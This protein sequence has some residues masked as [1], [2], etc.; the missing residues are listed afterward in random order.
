MPGSAIETQIVDV[1]VTP[2]EIADVL[3]KYREHHDREAFRNEV[4]PLEVTSMERIFR[5]L[6]KRH[7]IDFNH[8][9]PTTIG[10]RVKRR[11]E[12]DGAIG[13]IDDY[14][15]LLEQ[16]SGKL[17][18]L[19]RDLL[20]GVTRFFRDGEHFETLQKDV[21][22]GV[23]ANLQPNDEFR[24][25]VAACATGEEAYSIAILLDECLRELD[26][27][28][29]VKIFAT[30][31]HKASIE[32]ANAGIYPEE[33]LS[34]ISAER[35]ERYFIKVNENYQISPAIR[36]M[37]VFAPHNLVKDPPFT[38]LSLVT[39][40]NFLIYLLPASQ[41]KVI[42]LFHFGLR[43][44]GVLFLGSS[45]SPGDLADEFDVVHERHRV[46][47]KSRD[48]RLGAALP[49]R[50]TP[51]PL[52]N[53]QLARVQPAKRAEESDKIPT[54]ERLLEQF[55]PPSFLVDEH[56]RI[57]QVFGGAGKYLSVN[58]G[59]MSS[60]LLGMIGSD[61]KLAIGGAIQRLSLIHI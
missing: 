26:L 21:L 54:F 1:V 20:I 36:K 34:E 60:N 3:Q 57:I 17:D 12:M 31:L 44:G 19:Y 24:A 14:A 41:Q 58:D 25:W 51:H 37:V 49:G 53:Q 7:H 28:L 2:P 56:H 45:E 38:K 4:L 13:D 23:L 43:A 6:H 42:S 59:Q 48:V 18:Q 29:D 8:Y 11:I 22:P 35:R 16:D 32:T 10:R 55:M 30:D 52:M 50:V 40:R 46:F 33:S 39:C 15:E 5:A 47:R 27:Q 61:L 9:K